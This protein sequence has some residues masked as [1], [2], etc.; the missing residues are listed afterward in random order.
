MPLPAGF[1]EDRSAGMAF[2]KPE[3][4]IIEAVARGRGD[5][6]AVVSFYRNALPELG[7]AAESDAGFLAWRR[8]GEALRLEVTGA[9]T[10]VVIRFHIAPQ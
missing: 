10:E 7:W 1:S 3:G 8:E 9:G 5:R 2:D 6:A 4:R